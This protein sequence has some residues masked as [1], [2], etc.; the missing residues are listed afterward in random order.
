MILADKIKMLKEL[1]IKADYNLLPLEIVQGDAGQRCNPH[2]RQMVNTNIAW[3][4]TQ[5]E[6]SA[7][8]LRSATAI[9]NETK[10]MMEVI[11]E[12]EKELEEAN[13][14]LQNNWGR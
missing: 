11:L 8:K 14:R 5:G 12:L 9:F 4:V 1:H 2:Q 7:H 10:T 13:I 6:R 3:A